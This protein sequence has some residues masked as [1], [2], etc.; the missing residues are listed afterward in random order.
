MI[1]ININLSNV[2]PDRDIQSLA[3]ELSQ[4]IRQTTGQNTD[5]KINLRD[6]FST[7]PLGIHSIDQ[8]QKMR[9]L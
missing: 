5:V 3:Q 2:D 9:R 1:N 7:S 6:N 4:V 8:I